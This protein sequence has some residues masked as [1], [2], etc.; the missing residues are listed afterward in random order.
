MQDLLPILGD[1][2]TDGVVLILILWWMSNRITF[3]SDR[4]DIVDAT[5]DRKLNNGI[6]SRLLEIEKSVARIEGKMEEKNV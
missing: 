1:K 2:I 5:V 6:G 3:L 4:I